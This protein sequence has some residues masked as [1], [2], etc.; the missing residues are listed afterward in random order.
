M[1]R[2]REEMPMPATTLASKDPKRE[3]LR[4]FKR[5]LE[6]DT[7]VPFDFDRKTPFCTVG[8]NA[9]KSGRLDPETTD[10]L[11]QS[12]RKDRKRN[13]SEKA[14]PIDVVLSLRSLRYQEK[15]GVVHGL[16]LVPAILDAEGFLSMDMEQHRPWIPLE[17]LITEQGE[18]LEVMVGELKDYWDFQ[19]REASRYIS[20]VADWADYI[21]YAEALFDS[22]RKDIS[23]DSLAEGFRLID[24]TCFVRHG[25]NLS[26]NSSLIQLYDF[27]IKQEKLP[28]LLDRALTP[29]KGQCSDDDIDAGENIKHNM[30]AVRGS[31]NS[32]FPLADSQREAV[33][34]YS[35]M[36]DG[37]LLAVSGPPGTGKT[38]L[39]QSIVASLI[40]D[41]AI[42][43]KDAPLIVGTSATNQA[44]TNIIESFGNIAADDGDGLDTRWLPQVDSRD[45]PLR[46]IAAY[47]PSKMNRARFREKYLLVQPDKTEIYSDYSDMDYVRDAELFFLA[48]VD[49]VFGISCPSIKSAK[50]ELRR[51][52]EAVEEMQE[53][54]VENAYRLHERYAWGETVMLLG[55]KADQLQRRFREQ[56]E[57]LKYWN[58]KMR[59]H[60]SFLD[61][62]CSFLGG[63]GKLANRFR[64]KTQSA[65][66]VSYRREGETI[67]AGAVRLSDVVEYYA[68]KCNS[69]D[70]ERVRAVRAKSEIIELQENYDKDACALKREWGVDVLPSI[71]QMEEADFLLLLDRALDTSLRYRAFWLAVH[72]F[73][74][75]WL[76]DCEQGLT[77]KEDDR[78]KNSKPIQDRFWSQ[79]TS[80]TPCL[81]MTEYQMPKYFSLFSNAKKRD[82]DLEKIDLLIVDEAGQITSPVAL[83]ALGLAKRSVVVGDEH[84]LSPVW[85][86]TSEADRRVARSSGLTEADWERNVEMGLTASASSSFMRVALCAGRWRCSQNES[87]LFLREHYRCVEEI[88]QFCNELMYAGRLIP[89]RSAKSRLGDAPPFI[90][91]PL[92]DS[93]DRKAGSSRINEKEADAIVD[94]IAANAQRLEGIYETDLSK[95]LGIVTPFAAQAALIEGRIAENIPSLA[96]KL[97][98]GTAHKLQGA[99]RSVILFSCVYGSNSA[100]ASFIESVPELINVAV[101]RAKDL[102]VVFGDERRRMDT[103]R[104]FGLLN[105]FSDAGSLVGSDASSRG[106]SESVRKSISRLVKEWKERG[107]VPQDRTLTPQQANLHLKSAGLI[108]RYGRSSWKPT[109]R[110]IDAGI[111]GEEGESESGKYVFCT[112]DERA[113]QA[114]LKAILDRL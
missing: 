74:A 50:I 39:L 69:L 98:V 105:R 16:L 46:S 29:R 101:S 96:G 42:K 88:I 2:D 109:E 10:A 93:I 28:S 77:I 31:M 100:E 38:T 71:D 103:G 11:F 32:R 53:R 22:V 86:F 107:L 58:E 75:E 91:V 68:A 72:I 23:E 110:G 108:M 44:V 97:T 35:M 102:F 89:S 3:T 24:D 114:A 56:Q 73:E 41:H 25:S 90:F 36:H 7:L 8:R 34:A 13:R 106:E 112:Y 57:N 54:V 43:G 60:A 76:E 113:A 9:I 111:L 17:R 37:E 48:Q 1:I 40:V 18:S 78:W 83:A 61:R 4:Y 21:E 49:N 67:P 87:G 19:I 64:G 52:L 94:W 20:Q 6:L 47:C 51:R 27:L 30:I 33:H 26:F 15:E 45:E 63:V 92:I 65:L 82:Y 80:L 95:I 99:E 66:I 85:A 59:M 84:Q 12:A 62:L 55:K 79:I 5:A 70:E 104:V 14:S 81:V